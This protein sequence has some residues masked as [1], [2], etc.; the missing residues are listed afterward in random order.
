MNLQEHLT[1]KEKLELKILHTTLKLRKNRSAIILIGVNSKELK[2]SFASYLTQNIENLKPYEITS[3]KIT[4]DIATTKNSNFSNYFLIDLFKKEPMDEYVKNLNFYRDYVPQ[5]KLKLIFLL[6]NLTLENIKAKAYDFFST[7][8]FSFS[9][10]DHAHY[11]NNNEKKYE[12][13]KEALAEYQNYQLQK[14]KND[15]SELKIVFNIA[16]KAYEISELET[17]LEYFEKALNI[18]KR[19]FNPYMASASLGNIGLIYQDRG[20]LDK[21]LKYQL[22]A[23]KIEQENGFLQGEADTLANIGITYK[24]KG[25][26]DRALKYLLDAL[27]IMQDNGFLQ[28]EATALANIGNIYQDRGDNKTALKYFKEALNIAQVANFTNIIK[29]SEERIQNLKNHL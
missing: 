7:N 18:S 14:N 29:K 20:D 26:L 13:L 21:S 22:D 28:G 23:L 4:L 25:D 27:K 2:D 9:F 16:L 1:S 10:S 19:L 8:S 6:D 24:N 3:T 15:N 12:K 11:N 5:Q 17:A